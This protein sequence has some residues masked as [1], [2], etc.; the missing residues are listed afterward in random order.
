MQE[1]GTFQW[2]VLL[3]LLASLGWWGFV[4]LRGLFKRFSSRRW[5]T[6]EA[7]VQ[8]GAVG[9][10]SGVRGSWT[11]GS[12]FG[13]AFAVQGVSYMGLFLVVGDQEQ[14]SAL[15]NVL[16]GMPLSVRYKPSD[17]SVS[18]V[19]DLYDPRFRGLNATQ[20]PEWLKQA[21]TFSIGDVLRN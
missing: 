14:V 13:Y 3:L 4:Q 2:L 9:R 10:V 18:V 16:V 20:D 21:P 19:E 1:P 8:K 5:P 7:T 6:A 11:Y 15:Q 12:F 17:P